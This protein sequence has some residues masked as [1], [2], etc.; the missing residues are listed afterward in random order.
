ME[1]DLD[2]TKLEYGAIKGYLSA[3]DDPYTRF[4]EPKN[5]NE[6]QIR[7]SG[8]FYGIGIH[9]GMRKE[10]LMVISPINGTPA[11][12]AGL[13]SL[14]VIVTIDGKSASGLSLNEAVQMIRGPKGT[15]VVL[16]IRREGVLDPFDVPIVRDKIVLRAVDKIEVLPKKIGDVSIPYSIGYIRLT[17]FETQTSTKEVADAVKELLGKNIKGL[18]LD[19]RYNGGGLLSNAIDIAS[20]FIE[21]G[22]VVHT[23]NRDGKKHT[24]YVSGLPVYPKDKLIVLINEGSASASEILAGS[25]QDN[26]RGKLIGRQS[27]GKASVQKILKLP[28]GSAVLYTIAKYYT[29]NGTDITKKGIKVDIDAVIPTETIKLMQDPDYVYSYDTDPQLQIAVKEMMTEN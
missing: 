25:I 21:K 13:K 22:E 9:I 1:R 2:S 17:T 29:P 26:K 19:L 7:M 24:E 14:D 3:I 18:I 28:D 5:F 11:H 27:F 6:M 4:L 8:E 20:L 16:G 23:V 12:R 15:T 10:E